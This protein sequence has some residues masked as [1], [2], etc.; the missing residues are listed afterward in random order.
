MNHIIGK[1]QDA[2]G[3]PCMGSTGCAIRLVLPSSGVHDQAEPS[4]YS[5]SVYANK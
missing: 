2:L 4:G 1:S 3:S 5:L